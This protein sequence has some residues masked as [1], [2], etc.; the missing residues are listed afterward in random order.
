MRLTK[1]LTSSKTHLIEKLCARPASTPTAPIDF[2]FLGEP[3]V[4]PPRLRG[5]ILVIFHESFLH[6]NSESFEFGSPLDLGAVR[7]GFFAAPIEISRFE[8]MCRCDFEKFSSVVYALSG[9]PLASRNTLERHG[10]DVHIAKVLSR[11]FNTLVIEFMWKHAGDP[12]AC[13]FEFALRGTYRVAQEHVALLAVPDAYLRSSEL[14]GLRRF[15]RSVVSFNAKY[16]V[17]EAW[18]RMKSVNS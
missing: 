10:M 5:S 15:G 7:F 12:H 13:L 14:T 16:G 2:F 8:A 3:I 1:V 18:L 17:E 6:E 4:D 9:L 11:F